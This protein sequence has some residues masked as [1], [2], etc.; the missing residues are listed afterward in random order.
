MQNIGF[1]FPGQ[2]SQAMGMSDELADKYPLVKATY[3]EASTVL[4]YDLWQLV[5]SGPEQ[6]L[7]QTEFTQ[8]ALL[9]A[10]VAIWRIWCGLGGKMPVLLAGH[11]LGEYTALV[12]SEAITFS[13]AIK[14]VAKR[15]QL[16]QA[17][18]A[19]DV[20]AMAAII[21]LED[22]QVLAVCEQAALNQMVKPA[23]FNAPGQ[24]VVAGHK[25]AVE[26]VIELAKQQ[27]A[28]LAKL[29][30]VSV[31]SHC[32]LMQEA[33]N[34]LADYLASIELKTP[35]IA[36]VNNIDAQIKWYPD[37]IKRALVAQLANPVQW[38]K[39]IEYFVKQVQVI[40]ECGPGKILAG[41]NKRITTEVNTLTINNSSLIQEAMAKL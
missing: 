40:V 38:V 30:P 21:G 27:G 4:G 33:A 25:D 28:R 17:A 16:M 19:A 20:G 6:H 18:V 11:S 35:K 2:G 15:G 23:N 9:A 31:P 29:I 1:V 14:L 22:S 5:H 32:P 10:S 8:P 36:V 34:E 26:R 24:V 39:T 41:L 12:C 37:D 3:Q 7:N 13:E